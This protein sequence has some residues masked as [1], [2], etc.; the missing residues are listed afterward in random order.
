M[1]DKWTR[2]SI[3]LVGPVFADKLSN[4]YDINSSTAPIVWSNKVLNILA[5]FTL[6]HSTR[7]FQK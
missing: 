2:L 4:T 6:C 1:H 3:E 5:E 7:G